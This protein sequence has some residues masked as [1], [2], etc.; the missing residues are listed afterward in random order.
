MRNAPLIVPKLC[1]LYVTAFACCLQLTCYVH[2]EPGFSKN[3]KLGIPG[4]KRHGQAG[5]WMVLKPDHLHQSAPSQ[6]RHFL[7]NL[8]CTTNFCCVTVLSSQSASADQGPGWLAGTIAAPQCYLQ[9]QCVSSN[10]SGALTHRHDIVVH[11]HGV[12]T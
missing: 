9:L 5:A 12:D 6:K 3:Q 8:F 7:E 10:L 11:V 1:L 2:S 4:S